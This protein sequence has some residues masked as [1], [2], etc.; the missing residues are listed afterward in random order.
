NS[1]LA[2]SAFGGSAFAGSAFPAS[3]GFP[4]S[5]ACVGAATAG[6]GASAAGGAA[7]ASCGV[8]GFLV[9][10]STPSTITSA[11]SAAATIVSFFLSCTKE[12]MVSVTVELPGDC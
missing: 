11:P 8:E 9:A 12:G 6:G 5:G 2:D 10:T 4:V 7:E 3:A 1:G